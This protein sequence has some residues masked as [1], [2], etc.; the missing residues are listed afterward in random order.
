MIYTLDFETKPIEKFSPL[1]PEPVGLALKVDKQPSVYYSFGHINGQNNCTKEQVSKILIDICK[2]C[3]LFGSRMVF[4]NAS[5]DLKVMKV[6]FP[7]I[8]YI[9]FNKVDDT[10]FLSVLHNPYEEKLGLK[11]LAEK[12]LGIPPEARDLMGEWL[13]EHIY[14]PDGK[15][16]SDKPGGK[17]Y[18][19]K[20]TYC[21][22]PELAGKYACMDTDMTYE[23]CEQLLQNIKVTGQERAYERELALIPVII[24]NE[25]TGM[26]VNSELIER[27]LDEYGYYIDW[28]DDFIRDQLKAPGLNLN[29]PRQ[30]CRA[31]L[32]AGILD[33][34]KLK[35]SE[36]SG[37]YCMSKKTAGSAY[38]DQKFFKLMSY[39]NRIHTCHSTF[40]KPWSFMSKIDG[41]NL[42]YTSWNQV[43]SPRGGTKTGRF[44]STPNFQ[45]L[46]GAASVEDPPHEEIR[47]FFPGH[48]FWP[49]PE[50]R[51]YVVP[52]DKG[53]CLLDRDWSQQELKITGH[54]STSPEGPGMLIKKYRE[55]PSFDLHSYVG[56]TLRNQFGIDLKRKAVK[57]VN[58]G[59][60]YGEGAKGLSEA[61]MISKEDAGRIRDAVLSTNIDL[62]YLYKVTRA[63]DAKNQPIRTWGGRLYYTEP[64]IIYEGKKIMFAYRLVN[65]LIQGSAGDIIKEVWTKIG[66]NT[67][68][69]KTYLTVHDQ[70]LI[71]VPIENARKEMENLSHAMED[72]DLDIPL[73]SD[74][75]IS[76]YNWAEME[77]FEGDFNA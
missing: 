1:P 59:I 45:N 69:R 14:T 70:F 29:S 31:M 76:Y 3:R 61:L 57:T 47:N 19:V 73:T 63:R 33:E 30:L 52:W 65:T 43:R 32:S 48:D 2:D 25:L 16:L 12:Y 67:E 24:D 44:S 60:T 49:L 46:P 10:L 23:L 75:K 51:S 36:K 28:L 54:F 74:G 38:K 5:F 7:D 22:P 4:H 35:R 42:V 26:R 27:D 37:Q 62:D 34:T 6:H 20:Y 18:F 39:R 8:P 77:P 11:P 21:A 64:P 71:S 56:D 72:I 68:T 40:M 13:M 15:K 50:I 41:K 66:P 58:F 9:P 17:E 55:D 53:W